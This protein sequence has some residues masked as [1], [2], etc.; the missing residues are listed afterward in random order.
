MGTQT[1]ARP[2]ADSP[3]RARAASA[4]GPGSSMGVRCVG[5]GIP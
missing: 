4:A 2:L 3:T 5:A 1:A